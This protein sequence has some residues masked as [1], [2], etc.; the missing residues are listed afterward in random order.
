M[1]A[2]NKKT[3]LEKCRDLWKW[4]AKNPQAEKRDWPG[5]A[6]I[7]EPVQGW[8]FACE[9]AGRREPIKHDP[10]P[11]VICDRCLLHGLWGAHCTAPTSPYFVWQNRKSSPEVRAAAARRISDYCRDLLT[12]MGSV[13]PTGSPEASV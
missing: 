1:I 12:Q 2:T 4:L 10:N 5:W 7:T 3:S 6:K 11:D 9:Y 8:C 13:K